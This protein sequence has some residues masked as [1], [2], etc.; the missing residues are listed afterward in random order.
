MDTYSSS[1]FLATILAWV[2]V[3]LASLDNIMSPPETFGKLSN[4]F[5]KI[6]FKI[7]VLTFNFF[8]INGNTFS[9]TSEIDLKICSFSIC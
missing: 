1:I 2:K 9:S 8:R 4:S 3:L 5:S 7:E 6:C